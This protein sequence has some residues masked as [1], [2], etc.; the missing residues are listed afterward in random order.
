MFNDLDPDDKAEFADY[1][2]DL[3]KRKIRRA[4]ARVAAA[5]RPIAQQ[6]GRRLRRR[7]AEPPPAAPAGPPGPGPHVPPPEEREPAAAAAPRAP[8]AHPRGPNQ[9]ENVPWQEVH[10]DRC[11]EVAGSYTRYAP[12]Q[13]GQQPKWVFRCFDRAIG[14]LAINAPLKRSS[15]ISKMTEDAVVA[16]IRDK[17]ECCPSA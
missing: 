1:G 2:A 11:G 14:Q 7:L 15:V 9:A 5:K 16:W 13:D 3:K 8:L 10:C 6:R 17:S 4:R 12:R